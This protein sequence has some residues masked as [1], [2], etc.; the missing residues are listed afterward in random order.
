[1]PSLFP[2]FYSYALIVPFLLRIVLAVAFIKYGAK[3][4][5]ETSSPLSKT[6]G[7]IMLASGA[8][9]VLGLFTQAAALGVMALLALIK[10]LKS[11]T[12]MTNITPESKMLTA[13]MATIAIAIF[14]LGPGI[15]SFDLP[16]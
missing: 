1:M 5:G 14:L 16:L 8:L 6:I 12:G 7:G 10:I 2:E 3:G 11:K 15:F 13:F 4:F 9:L